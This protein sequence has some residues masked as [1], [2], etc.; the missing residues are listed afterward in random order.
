MHNK[1]EIALWRLAI[2]LRLTAAAAAG[3]SSRGREREKE[4][5]VSDSDHLFD[6][7]RSLLFFRR[8]LFLLPLSSSSPSSSLFFFFQVFVKSR[9]LYD[10]TAQ[11]VSKLFLSFFLSFFSFISFSFSGYGC[12]D[13]LLLTAFL[14]LAGRQQPSAQSIHVDYVTITLCICL[15]H[16]IFH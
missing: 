3:A 1:H 8:R 15:S 16:W 6:S 4:A 2:S 10:S 12:L 9:S 5:V 14:C 7:I 11:Q 13:P